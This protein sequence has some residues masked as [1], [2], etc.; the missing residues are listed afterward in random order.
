MNH[1]PLYELRHA[2]SLRVPIELFRWIRSQSDAAGLPPATYALRRLEELARQDL[3]KGQE[4]GPGGQR[5]DL[6]LD[7][8]SAR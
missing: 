7:M 5:G 3:Q 8:G 2:M 1:F 4:D 6:G